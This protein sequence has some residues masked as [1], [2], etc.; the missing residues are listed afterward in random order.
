MRL[1]GVQAVD[2]R[3]SPPPVLSL[4]LSMSIDRVQLAQT[5]CHA[6]PPNEGV[7]RVCVCAT[8]FT[9]E[10]QYRDQHWLRLFSVALLAAVSVPI[11]KHVRK[12]PCGRREWFSRLG[13]MWGWLTVPCASSEVV[14]TT[15]NNIV[16][17]HSQHVLG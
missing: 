6:R 14:D 11:I 10:N 3:I 17:S 9:A 12:L 15:T 16:V 5:L 8:H 7:L 13:R 2:S 4:R 1:T